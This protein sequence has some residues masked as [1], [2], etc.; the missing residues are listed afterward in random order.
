MNTNR[1]FL[2]ARVMISHRRGFYIELATT[3]NKPR[4]YYW[5]ARSYHGDAVYAR[6]GPYHDAPASACDYA[7]ERWGEEITD[8]KYIPEDAN[9]LIL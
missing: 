9:R 4:R 5:S 7:L 1:I 6:L 3:A 2:S 8:C